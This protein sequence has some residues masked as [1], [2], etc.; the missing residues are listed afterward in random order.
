MRLL[1]EAA[2]DP[3][4]TNR[5]GKRPTALHAAS[6]QEN[7]KICMLLLSAKADPHATDDSGVSPSDYASCSEAVWPHF[8]AV[9]C[10]RTSKEELINKSVIRKASTALE[11][12]LESKGGERAADVLGGGDGVQGTSGILQEFSRPGS[13][14]VLMSKHPPRPGSAVAGNCPGSRSNSRSGKRPSGNPID[15]LVEGDESAEAIPANLD[16]T[17]SAVPRS[18]YAGGIPLLPPPVSSAPGNS[19][20]PG[21]LRSLG[22]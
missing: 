10:S 4:Q 7:G 17:P 19:T 21:S 20:V 11:L 3:R 16:A 22:L 14:Y 9:G 8:A 2:A 6:L 1:L 5:M 15:I 18:G 12:E 13:A